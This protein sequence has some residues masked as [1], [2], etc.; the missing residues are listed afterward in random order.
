MRLAAH[1]KI[2]LTLEVLGTRPDGYHDLR[3]VVTTIPLHDD[4]E[5]WD[6]P[7]DEVTVEMEGDGMEAPRVPCEA[8]L[9]VRAA[10]ALA[11]AAG[12]SHG[13]RIRIVKRIPVGAG[14][15]GG[16]ADAAA[17]LN[18]LNEMWGLNLP[19]ER[20]YAIGAEVGSDVPALVLGGTVLMEGRGERVRVWNAGER[21]ARRT[22]PTMGGSRSCATEFEWSRFVLR[23]PPISAST[24]RVYAE[25]REE[26]RGKFRNDLQ[27]A[28]CRLYP[29][30]AET[31]AEMEAE[32][33]EDVQ[34]TGSGSAVFGWRKEAR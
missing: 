19:R 25:F 33:L 12:V 16:S 23:V 34:M 21:R 8:N 29:A 1:A 6:A 3:S 26:D 11:A 32:G 22:R 2:N 10:R 9:A 4:V 28:A 7:A 14:L 18:G 13:V 15:G 17:V 31:V 24:A 27:P 5:L 20:L 30:I